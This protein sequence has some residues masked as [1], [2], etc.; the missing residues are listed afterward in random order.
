MVAGPPDECPS[1][2]RFVLPGITLSSPEGK[3]R[4]LSAGTLNL[5]HSIRIRSNTASH[6]DFRIRTVRPIVK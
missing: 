4:W 5:P 1:D 2:W 3:S 6:P